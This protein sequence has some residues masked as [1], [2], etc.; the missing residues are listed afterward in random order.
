MNLSTNVLIDCNKFE[1]EL[2]NK[3]RFKTNQYSKEQTMFPKTKDIFVYEYN[4]KLK[5]NNTKEEKN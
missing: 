4:V 1:F 2:I 5:D 3:T